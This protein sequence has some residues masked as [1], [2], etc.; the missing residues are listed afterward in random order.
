[1][2]AGLESVLELALAGLF[3]LCI[4]GALV[5]QVLAMRHKTPEAL[6]YMHKDSLFKNKELVYNE[7]GMRF[8]RM[9][10]LFAVGVMLIALAFIALYSSGSA[11]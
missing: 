6:K 8:I 10:K 9:Q 7:I 2:S 11:A 1:M 5:C 3:V 4:A